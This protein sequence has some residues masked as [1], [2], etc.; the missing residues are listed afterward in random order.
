MLDRGEA[1]P[2][3]VRRCGLGSPDDAASL[4]VWLAS[5]RS[6]DVTGQAIAIGGD[7]LGLWRRPTEVG[8]ASQDGR[9]SVH[10]IADYFAPPGRVKL[11]AFFPT[12]HANCTASCSRSGHG[13]RCW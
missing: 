11:Q 3:K 10:P 12:P 7:R 6:G 13:L 8:Y 1:L 5:A 2:P 9:W 4:V